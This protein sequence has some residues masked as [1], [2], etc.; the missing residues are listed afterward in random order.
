MTDIAPAPPV[1]ADSEYLDPIWGILRTPIACVRCGRLSRTPS[2]QGPDG[3][4]GPT[5]NPCF[6]RSMGY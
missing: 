1:D 4:T 3:P 6:L 5:C 2:Y